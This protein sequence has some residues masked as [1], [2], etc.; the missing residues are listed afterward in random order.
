MTFKGAKFETLLDIEQ[1]CLAENTKLKILKAK[2]QN[3]RLQ[4]EYTYDTEVQ[5]NIQ[6][7]FVKEIQGYR[8]TLIH[9]MNVF[10]NEL[11]DKETQVFYERFILGTSTV[12]IQDK[13]AISEPSLFRYLK[14]IENEMNTKPSGK[15]IETMLK[16]D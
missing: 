9:Q 13:L 10:A 14:T 16:K 12:E 5:V 3:E 7:K 1:L 8:D 2:L 11:N 4:R 15:S 6:S